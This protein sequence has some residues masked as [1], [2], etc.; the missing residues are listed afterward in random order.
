MLRTLQRTLRPNARNLLASTDRAAAGLNPNGTI[1]APVDL[2]PKITESPPMTVTLELPDEIGA[3]PLPNPRVLAGFIEA[4]LRRQ[5]ISS[6]L[7]RELS[8]M[9]ERLSDSPSAEEIATMRVSEEAQERMEDL[10]EKNREGT[11][12]DEDRR[13]WEEF[14][15]MECLVRMAKVSAVAKLQTR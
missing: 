6:P 7:L 12:T 14:E 13:E 4:G 1:A 10:L 15:R 2:Y 9:V 11:L 5:R 3:K 8:G